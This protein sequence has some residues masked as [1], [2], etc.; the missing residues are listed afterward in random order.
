MSFSDITSSSVLGGVRGGMGAP[1]PPRP[2]ALSDDT[3]VQHLGESLQRLER[4]TTSLRVKI[5]EMR[6]REVSQAA[7]RDLDRQIQETRNFESNLK[8]QVRNVGSK[9]APTPSC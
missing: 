1:R 3:S 4:S 8:T 6:R 2:P 7:K 5:T 9:G